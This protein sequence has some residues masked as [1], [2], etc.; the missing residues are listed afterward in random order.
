MGRVIFLNCFSKDMVTGGVKTV[1]QH[2]TL[3]RQQ[4]IEASVLQKDGAPPWMVDQN[5][6]SIVRETITLLDDDV[7]VFPE[8]ISGW[9][10][11]ILSQNMKCSK[12]IFCQNQYYFYTYCQSIGLLKNWGVKQ[13]IVPSRTAAHSLETM[14]GCE[15]VAVVP[16]VVD[17]RLFAPSSKKLQIVI[18]GWKWLHQ[19]SIPDYGELICCML[20][21]KYP[22]FVHV[23]WV[24]LS[25][26]TEGEVARIMGESAVC[27]VLGRLESLG[28]TALEAMSAGCL[29]V[30][31][32]G[33]AEYATAQNGMWHSPEDIESMVDSLAMALSGFSSGNVA[34]SKMV[35]HGRRT[36]RMYGEREAVKALR[37]AYGPLVNG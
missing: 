12:V 1:Y 27:L 28:L 5:I 13:F 19:G 35:E 14:M 32:H 34:L 36:A 23:P 3:L 18:A 8:M 20:R 7:L 11:D 21:A 31:C 29:L 17:E 24:R 4:G 26:Q 15:D 16:P 22:Q 6:S 33:G 10:Q 2:A 30:G 9:F 37:N 25:N